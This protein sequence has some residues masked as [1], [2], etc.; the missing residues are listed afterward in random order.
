MRIKIREQIQRMKPSNLLSFPGDDMLSRA[1][2]PS[3]ICA[4][5]LNCRVRDGNGW[6]PFAK[7]TRTHVSFSPNTSLA[8]TI[9]S[10]TY[11]PRTLP[12]VSSCR[13]V[14]NEKSYMTMAGL[15]RP[16]RCWPPPAT[17]SRTNTVRSFL[18]VAVRLATNEISC[19]ILAGL[20]RPAQ[21]TLSSLKTT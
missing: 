17:Q 4:E 5:G 15:F 2:R 9:R 7:I 13:L 10:V 8:S 16:W 14:L 20:F 1:L 18:P 11:K 3:T 19:A 6:D 12:P 21:R